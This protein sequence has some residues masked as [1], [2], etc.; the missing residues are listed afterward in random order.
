MKHFLYFYDYLPL[1]ISFF[2]NGVCIF[3]LYADG[4][5][6]LADASKKVCYK[7]RI[8][9]VDPAFQVNPDTDMDPRPPYR[10][11]MLQENPSALK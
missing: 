11:S 5:P 1:Y 6:E 4:H 9:V 3:V 8:S 7:V 10:T 2:F